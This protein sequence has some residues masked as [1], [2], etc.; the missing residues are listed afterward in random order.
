MSSGSS[1]TTPALKSN[2][3]PSADRGRRRTSA[4]AR[5]SVRLRLH[6][7]RQQQREL[8]AA[9]AKP[10]VDAG[11]DRRPDSRRQLAQDLVA[12]AVAEA[13]VD[14]LELVD[15]EIDDAERLARAA[16]AGA[17]G[18]E[19]GLE[20]ASVEEAGETV[21]ARQ[22]FERA[23]I[24]PH[25]PD[26]RRDQQPAADFGEPAAARR[27]QRAVL[28]PVRDQWHRNEGVQPHQRPEPAQ[29]R[30]RTVADRRCGRG[31]SRRGVLPRRGDLVRCRCVHQDLPA[32]VS[33]ST[34]A[35]ACTNRAAW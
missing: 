23:S 34:R 27:G 21:R 4:G 20:A 2:A 5:R 19:R 31:K 17:L 29:Q 26:Q 15:V 33:V 28:D 35:P 14:T 18:G 6:G 12:G 22:R 24:A 32:E 3:P 7:R 13:V 16:S 11:P 25:A 9:E 1:S 30:R 10:G 8:V